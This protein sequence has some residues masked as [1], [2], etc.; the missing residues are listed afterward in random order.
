VAHAGA[1]W[2]GCSI[3]IIWLAVLFV[4][5]FGGAFVS[6]SSANW[7]TKIPVVV[8][9][10]PSALPATIVVARRGFAIASD[11]QH[12]APDEEIREREGPTAEPSALRTG[13]A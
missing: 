10:L 9:L 13:A 3:I 7:F 12:G 11:Q 6:S 1:V 2:A 5:V 8:F 4:G